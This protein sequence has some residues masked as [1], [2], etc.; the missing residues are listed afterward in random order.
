MEAKGNKTDNKK[1]ALEKAK[2]P[3]E[4]LKRERERRGLSIDEVSELT[5]IRPNYISAIES[6]D[7]ENLPAGVFIRG[8]IRA[9]AKALELDERELLNMMGEMEP[10]RLTLPKVFKRKESSKEKIFLGIFCIIFITVLALLINGYIKERGEKSGEIQRS[11]TVKKESLRVIN[12]D[13]EKNKKDEVVKG[14]SPSPPTGHTLQC[15][16]KVRTWMRVKIDDSEPREYIF[17]PGAILKWE[18]KDRFEL[19]IGNAGG[20][21]ISFDG[22]P[23]GELGKLGQVVR[24]ILPEKNRVMEE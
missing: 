23:L 16:V 6:N 22:R 18:A 10:V 14:E 8:F 15:K 12:K 19:L 3:G 24:L 20:V 13:T 4:I 17:E 1:E 21:D 9:Y 5:R 7:Q 11:E 2:H